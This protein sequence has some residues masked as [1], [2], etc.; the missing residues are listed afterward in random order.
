[1]TTTTTRDET[2]IRALLAE[3]T[4]AFAAQDAE[5]VLAA[6][7]DGAVRYT[8]APPLVQGPDTA[9]GDAEGPQTWFATFDGPVEISYRDAV[10]TAAGD[11]AFTHALTSMTATPAV[12][13]E[14]FTLWFR[15]TFGCAGSTATGASFT[16]MS[17]LRSHGRFFQSSGR[18]HA[19]IAAGE[20]LSW[21][22]Q[23]AT[24]CRGGAQLVG[25][26]S[27]RVA[28]IRLEV[29]GPV[30]TFVLLPGAGG[31]AWYWSR[32]VPLLADAGHEAIAVDLP[33]HDESAGLAEYARIVV[34]AVGDRRD[35]PTSD[36]RPM[37]SSR[38]CAT[39]PV[40]QQYRR[41]CCLVRRTDSFPSSFSAP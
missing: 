8:L 3:N 9:Y 25:P 18:P 32:V 17:P 11:V 29:R 37:Q 15:S 27:A 35:R 20:L 30:S 41:A 19:V 26:A 7:A 38:R 23:S 16:S 2:D 1:M 24:L 39:S 36:L 6:Y 12:A 34:D 33:G 14:S 5:R 22:G 21:P 10:V 13:P 31:S 4:A 28:G 40:G